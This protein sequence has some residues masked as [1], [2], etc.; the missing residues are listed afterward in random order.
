LAGIQLS[1]ARVP[2]QKQ[3]RK[4]VDSECVRAR[5]KR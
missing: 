2:S 4:K 1:V 3:G 5:H